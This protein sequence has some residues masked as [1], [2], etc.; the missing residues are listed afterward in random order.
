VWWEIQS[1]G[2]S[3]ENL[4]CVVEFERPKFLPWREQVIDSIA[5][6]LNTG[7]ER[8][9]VKAKTNEKQDSVGQGNAIK[10]YAVCLLT[11]SL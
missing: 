3:L 8:I 9:F 4:D 1:K 10:S 6:V 11:K 5:N 7:R 2:W